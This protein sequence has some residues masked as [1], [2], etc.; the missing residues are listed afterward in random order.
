MKILIKILFLFF[1]HTLLAQC[2]CSTYSV[3]YSDSRLTY[4]GRWNT[5][6]GKW[7]AWGGAQIVFKVQGTR[8]VTIIAS[9]KDTGDVALTALAYDVDNV[10]AN[11]SP[12]IFYTTPVD[13]YTGAKRATIELSNTDEHTI[14]LKSSQYPDD[15]FYQKS[16]I[17]ITSIEINPLGFISIWNQGAKV[18]QCVGDSWMGTQ[19]DWPRLM[20]TT[21]YKLYPIANGGYDC[22]TMNSNYNYDYSG[23]INTTDV[24]ADAV[25]VSFG[26]N[27]FNFGI[28]QAAFETSLYSLVD[29]I[30]A[31]QPTAKI[32]L[33]RVPKNIGT[34]NDFGKYGTN[35]NNVA[36]NRSN[37]VYID[38]TSLDATITWYSDNYHLNG[39]GKQTLADFVKAILISNGI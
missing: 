36:N 39:T 21:S 26:V 16:K 34:G 25:I 23:V 19:C 15:S 27:D 32:F 29:K 18:I 6:T 20:S 14:T 37:V 10:S 11:I 5:S 13:I 33:I 4:L 31:K 7:S 30:R 3:D 28:T 24:N 8:Y 12:L 22:A 38:T 1:S 2:V 9:V 35:M 17:T